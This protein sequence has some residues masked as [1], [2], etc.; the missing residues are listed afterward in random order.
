MDEADVVVIGG[1]IIGSAIAYQLAVRDV[2]RVMVVERGAGPAE[3]ST[4]ASSSIVRTLYSRPETVRLAMGG[5]AAYRRW[6]EFTQLEQPRSQFHPV[7]MV[8]MMGYS[9]AEAAEARD[10]LLDQGGSAEVLDAAGVR[11]RFPALSACDE[12][13][14]LT[15]EVPHECRDLK[16]ALFEPDAGFADPTGATQDLI[17]AARRAGAEVSFRSEVQAV[18]K[19]GNRVS[20]VDLTDGR[21]IRA[22]LII[23]AA[24]PWCN[25]L[26][27]MAG[28]RLGW[29]IEPTRV[30]VGYRLRPAEVPGPIPI[31]ADAS[32][33]IYFRP[34]ALG[35][36]VLFGSVLAEDEKEH[37][38]PD[39]FNPVADAAFL[40]NKI[41]ALHH[42]LPD[43]PY[44]G[45]LSGIAG[46]YAINE[47]DVHPVLGPTAV[48][49]WWVANGFS[50]HGFK[51]A[52]MIGSMIARAITGIS[53]QFDTD[54]PMSYF[55]LD[56]K[57]LSVHAKNVLA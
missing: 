32:T 41:H 16:A 2:G 52:P 24:G 11:G 15:G 13:F 27:D 6:D 9:I 20:G 43:L 53:R 23:N 42:R 10:R 57:P 21:T 38:D 56:R 33:G 44:R 18:R 7:G 54:I 37:V 14:D 25:R 34:E 17:E 55:G 5:Q 30:Q 48:E 36:Q 28:A 29:T 22:P 49:G 19:D 8:W 12:P 26:N 1:G 4:G 40:N 35:Q 50:G 51:L 39:S 3:G 47:K 46:L 31:V 45:T